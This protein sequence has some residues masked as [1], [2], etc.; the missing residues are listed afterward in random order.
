MSTTAEKLLEAIR[1]L[2]EPLLADVLE[3]VESLSYQ[4]DILKI[5]DPTQPLS[6]LS[7]GLELSKTF[8][9]DPL[10]IQQQLRNEWQRVDN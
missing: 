8:Y 9:L 7:G 3:F 2:P 4:R 6:K 5:V 1:T 10:T